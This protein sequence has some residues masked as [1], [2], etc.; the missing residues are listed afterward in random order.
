MQSDKYLSLK[1]INIGND[2]F[3]VESNFKYLGDAIG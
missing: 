2:K 1:E 3:H